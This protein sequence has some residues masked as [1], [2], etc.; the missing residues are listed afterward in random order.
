MFFL[1]HWIK[2]QMRHMK[3]NEAVPEKLMINFFWPQLCFFNHYGSEIENE[4]IC[5]SK[6]IELVLVSLRVE[7]WVSKKP[8]GGSILI[9]TFPTSPFKNHVMTM[10]T[11]LMV[12]FY[13][14][15]IDNQIKRC[16]KF[17]CPTLF[18]ITKSVMIVV[19]VQ[20]LFDGP[21]IAIHPISG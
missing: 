21:E 4:G 1:I 19:I 16:M 2:W 12:D 15:Q 14:S 11:V 20:P 7:Q 6:L 13:Y 5:V 10:C 18:K 17:Y 9:C 8:L 3:C